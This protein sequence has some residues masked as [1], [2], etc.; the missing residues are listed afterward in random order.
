MAQVTAESLLKQLS[1]ATDGDE[2]AM[3]KVLQEALSLLG[4][5]PTLPVESC[6]VFF[7]HLVLRIFHVNSTRYKVNCGSHASG[8]PCPEDSTAKNAL[9]L[10]FPG[11]VRSFLA[12]SRLL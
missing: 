2:A 4:D 1:S 10:A 8:N 11:R 3:R 9:P 5:A 7:I 12:M 6:A